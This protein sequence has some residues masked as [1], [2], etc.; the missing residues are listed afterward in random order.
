MQNFI[1]LVSS[2]VTTKIC[3]LTATYKILALSAQTHH[4]RREILE[5]LPSP[6]LAPLRGKGRLAILP[7]QDLKFELQPRAWPEKE[8]FNDNPVLRQDGIRITQKM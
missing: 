8:I 1:N 4:F 5:P 2:H 7:L 3:A 6:P